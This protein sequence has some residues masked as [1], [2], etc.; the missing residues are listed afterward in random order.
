M[1]NTLSNIFSPLFDSL[2]CYIPDEKCRS[3]NLK[4]LTTTLAHNMELYIDKT[5]LLFRIVIRVVLI[6]LI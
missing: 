3:F 5:R 6:F 1:F 2:A 4:Q